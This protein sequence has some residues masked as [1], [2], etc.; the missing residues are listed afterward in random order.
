MGLDIEQWDE[1]DDYKRSHALAPALIHAERDA[2]RCESCGGPKADCQ[3]PDNQ[4]AYV[5]TF[6]RCYRSA[7]VVAAQKARQDMDGVLTV[8][9]LDPTRKKSARAKETGRG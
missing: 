9:T 6:R 4:H 7:A 2:G 1:L 3:D 5:V 8:V